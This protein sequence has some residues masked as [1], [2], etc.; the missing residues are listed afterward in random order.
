MAWTDCVQH[1]VEE[2]EKAEDKRRIDGAECL[3][4]AHGVGHAL[5]H[6]ALAFEDEVPDPVRQARQ[7]NDGE[8]SNGD[9]GDRDRGHDREPLPD[10]AVGVGGLA[11]NGHGSRALGSRAIMISGRTG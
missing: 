2:T 5:G 3:Q 1:A 8:Q 9:D 7:Q 11:G 6:L 4:L 10:A